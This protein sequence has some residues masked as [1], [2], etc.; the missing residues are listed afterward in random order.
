MDKR[1]PSWQVG[2]YVTEVLVHGNKESHH[3]TS[4]PALCPFLHFRVFNLFPLDS[5]THS[6][7]LYL[8]YLLISAQTHL[9][10]DFTKWVYLSISHA[11]FK[12]HPNLL[13]LAFILS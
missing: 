5:N 6:S 12:L 4:A 8:L 10:Y 11:R 13:S 9:K 3:L 2:M 1:H 7:I